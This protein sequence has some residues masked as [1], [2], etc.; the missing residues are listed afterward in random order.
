MPPTVTGRMR[1]PENQ[2]DEPPRSGGFQIF[3]NP[4]SV[5]KERQRL[6]GS[7]GF[8]ENRAERAGLIQLGKQQPLGLENLE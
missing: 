1:L 8:V 2:F 7:C 5:G 4:L 6:A 3:R